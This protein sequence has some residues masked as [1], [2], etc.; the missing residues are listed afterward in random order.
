MKLERRSTPAQP[1]LP[2]H[3]GSEHEA[4]ARDV[5]LSLGWKPKPVEKALAQVVEELEGE[6]D[7][8]DTL[9][10]AALAKLMEK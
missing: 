8:L 5:L 7:N 2:K 3:D 6:A 10:R 1:E 4:A 9:V